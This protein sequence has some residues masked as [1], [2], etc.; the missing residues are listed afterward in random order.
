M[1]RAFALASVVALWLSLGI[2]LPSVASAVNVG[3]ITWGPS[4]TSATVTG[5]INDTFT[6]SFTPSDS[7]SVRNDTGSVKEGAT[8]CGVT[9]GIPNC[10]WNPGPTTKVLTITQVGR[11]AVWTSVFKGYITINGSGG[12]VTNSSEIQGPQPIM[13][14]FGKPA[15]VSCNIAQPAGLNWAGVPSGGWSESWA[16]WVNGGRGGAVC[17]RTLSFNNSI[18]RWVLE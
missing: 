4:T 10:F 6:F 15:Q 16:Q 12:G 18:G 3:T 9:G 13:Q 5:E 17:A 7:G 2:V 11:I 8:V 1:K 14:Q